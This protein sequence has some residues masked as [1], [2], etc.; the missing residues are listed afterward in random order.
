MNMKKERNLINFKYGKEFSNHLLEQYKLYVETAERVSDRRQSANNFYLSLNS[1]ISVLSGYLSAT[2]KDFWIILVAF[3]GILI[4]LAWIQNINSY[5]QL[6]SAKFKVIHEMEKYLPAS[7]FKT[8]W[9]DYLEEGKGEKYKKL[10]TV[11][12]NVP[13]IFIILYVI[14]IVFS[15][16]YLIGIL[17]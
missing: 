5:K 11:E 13:K 3:T 15:I 17:F 10:T 9:I 1:A 16:L 8:E 7:L 2:I 6:N 14:I 4:S 12:K